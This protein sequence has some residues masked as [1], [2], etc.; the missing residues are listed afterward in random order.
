MQ[1]IHWWGSYHSEEVQSVYFTT[2]ADWASLARTYLQQFYTDK[3]FTQEYP[4]EVM[5]DWNGEGES[6]KSA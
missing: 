1:N 4:P 6:G 3:E 5:V 2:P